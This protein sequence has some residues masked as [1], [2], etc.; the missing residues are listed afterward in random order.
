LSS[1]SRHRSTSSL[2]KPTRAT[3][4]LA[5]KYEDGEDNVVA[6]IAQVLRARLIL[7]VHPDPLFEEASHRR[8]TLEEAE[9]SLGG[10]EHRVGGVCAHGGVEVTTICGAKGCES[11][12]AR[13][14]VVDSC[15][16]VRR[17]S[18]TDAQVIVLP[19]R[20]FCTRLAPSSEVGKGSVGAVAP[21]GQMARTRS[22]VRAEGCDQRLIGR[23]AS[24]ISCSSSSSSISP[25]YSAPPR[26]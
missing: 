7:L 22:A 25:S 17:V 6:K 10:I 1:R 9:S 12:S 18:L 11:R 14:G 5:M 3:R 2:M 15:A 20:A 8:T 19:V 16:M 23:R 26:A 21:A 4:Q 13:S 24:W